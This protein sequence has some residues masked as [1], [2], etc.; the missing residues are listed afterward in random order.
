MSIRFWWF[1]VLA[2]ALVCSRRTLGQQK[3]SS[4]LV[5]VVTDTLELP[6]AQADV[7][8]PALGVWVRTNAKGEFKLSDLP[9]GTYRILVR[10]IGYSPVEQPVI[11]GPGTNRLDP[12]R[13]LRITTLDTVVTRSS[14]RDPGMEEFAERRA[15]GLGHFVTKADLDQRRGAILSSFLLQTPGVMVVPSTGKEWIGSKRA[16]STSCRNAPSRVPPGGMS[17]ASA[18]CLRSEGLYYVPDEPG[19]PVICHARVFLDEALMNPGSPT[20]PFDLRSVLTTQVEGMEWYAGSTQ[21]PIKYMAR[22]TS[23]GVLVIRTRRP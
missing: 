17:D 16:M 10:R 15:L 22:N 11:L 2:M 5:G 9:P 13:L 12:F 14:Y 23:C 20:P 7:S 4:A 8:L 21:V 3:T 1:A 6:L 19:A 18:R